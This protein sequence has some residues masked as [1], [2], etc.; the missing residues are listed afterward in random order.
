MLQTDTDAANELAERVLYDSDDLPRLRSI[1]NDPNR[2]LVANTTCA[3]CHSFNDQSFN[4]HNLSYLQ[5][6]E[7]T[8]APRVRNDVD[9]NLSWLAGHR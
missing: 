3:T 7:I 8:V 1:V 9:Y 2:T 6:S 5:E 4:F